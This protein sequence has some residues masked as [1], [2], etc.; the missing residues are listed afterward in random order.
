MGCG[1]LFNSNVFLFVFLPCVL[2]GFLLLRRT[3]LQ[4]L[5]F[6]YILVVSI[7][8]YA[9][10]SVPYTG[11]LLVSVAANFV[12]GW[13]LGKRPR[14]LLLVAALAGN[15]LLLGYF[16]YYNFAVGILDG[17]TSLNLPPHDVV[18]PIGISFYTFVQ[19]A[20]L[21]DA[22]SQKVRDYRLSSYGAFVTFFPHMLA[23]PIIH[24]SEMMP[25][26]SRALSTE[27]IRRMA[28]VGLAIFAMGLAKK[29]LIADGLS[30]FV[31]R[32]FDSVAQGATV[33]FFSAWSGV[34]MYTMQ[35]YFDF[36][37]YSDMAIGIALMFGIRFPANFNSPYKSKSIIDF[38]RRWH[39]TLSRLLRDYIYIP[40]G[41]SRR[42]R[43]RRYVNL[44]TTMLI[45]GIWHGAGWTFVLW[46]ALH[47]A[48]LAVAHLWREKGPRTA[49]FGPL[50]QITTFVAVV[51]AWVPF[52]AASWEAML[53]LYGAMFGAH[54][55]SLPLEAVRAA[56]KLHLD[57]AGL[58][59]KS[60]SDNHRTEFY[61]SLGL[62]VVAMAIAFRGP[63]TLQIMRRYTPVLETSAAIADVGASK[64]IWRPGIWSGILTGILLLASIRAMNAAA[65]T[66]FLY[67][68][69]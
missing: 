69:F 51:L 7:I 5:Q 53:E 9:Y 52:R 34:L 50:A 30:P 8:F 31:N 19:I 33:D 4:R 57:L 37:G 61:T 6:S 24:H 3:G 60:M 42:G 68:Q 22:Y 16:K 12:I 14:R 11:L 21:V 54:G 47:G 38:W 17:L 1:L 27:R 35:I 28:A 56:A 25:Q 44:F 10:W 15:L 46:G 2:A 65:S 55:L 66:E 41:G 64:L 13:A 23:G 20:F 36:S 45:G 39:M 32:T 62:L 63:N 18:L 43:G 67:F 59:I 40:L 48:Y 58:G 26:F 29:V 49:L